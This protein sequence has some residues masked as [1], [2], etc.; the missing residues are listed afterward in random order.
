MEGKAASTG[1]PKGDAAKAATAAAAAAAAAAVPQKPLDRAEAIKRAEASL[2]ASPVMTADFVQIGQRNA[3]P[4]AGC[5]STRSANALRICPASDDGGRLRRSHRRGAR[6]QAQHADLYFIA[7][8]PLKFLLNEKIDLKKDV[9]LLDVVID[10][11]Y[12]AIII[13]DKTTLGG[14]SKIKLLFDAKTFD[15]KQWRSP[16]RRAT[17]SPASLFNI[18]RD[19]APDPK[20]FKVAR[21]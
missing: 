18:D 15:L 7:Q 1:A 21:D 3:A 4:K 11:A 19:S 20:L 13:E 5:S 12:A 16:I 10:D 9:K 2:N 8:T 6:P 14:T 17:R